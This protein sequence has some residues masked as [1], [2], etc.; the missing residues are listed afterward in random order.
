MLI[1]IGCSRISKVYKLGQA[2]ISDLA[3]VAVANARVGMVEFIGM[4]KPHHINLCTT[5]L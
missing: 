1:L 3:S 4:L 2:R 5:H